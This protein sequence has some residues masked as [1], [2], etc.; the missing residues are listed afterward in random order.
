MSDTIGFFRL[1]LQ[2]EPH[3]ATL[4][5]HLAEVLLD[6]SEL[7]AAIRAASEAV[8]LDGKLVSAWVIRATALKCQGNWLEAM[9]DYQ[10]AARLA[11]DRSSVHV[12]AA[13]CAAELD[14]L[15]E[16]ERWLRRA[17]ALDPANKEAL[18]NLGSVLVRLDRLEDARGPCLAAL[19][20]DA[21]ILSA[22]QNL[23]EIL[24]HSDPAA[25]RAHR[26]FAYR[27]K[28][29]FIEPAYQEQC[30]VLVLSA[31]DA[32]NVPIRHIM[33][34]SRFTIIRWYV[35]YATPGQADQLPSYDLV[36]NAIGDPDFVPA[37]NGETAA[38][39]SAQGDRLLNPLA[40]VATTAR[41]TLSALLAGVPNILVPRTVRFGTRGPA[42][43]EAVCDA[44]VTF[45]VLVR[46]IGSHG[47]AGVIKA[48]G[49]GDL[50]AAAGGN[51]Y[52]TEFVD[53]QS[54]DAC[55][56]KYRVIFV[57]GRAYPYHLAIGPHWL[58]HYWTSGMEQAAWKRAEEAAFL[59]DPA[60]AIGGS[61]WAAMEEIGGRLQLHYA[62][63]DFGILADG[64]VIVFEANATMLVHPET[65]PA[66][67]YRCAAV[68]HIQQ[69]FADMIDRRVAGH[70]RLYRR[71]PN[72]MADRV[73]FEPT[74]PL[75]DR[76]FSRLE[77]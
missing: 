41:D 60:A 29:L 16:A 37:F 50:S 72:P 19:A 17:V 2:Q 35:E 6:A 15:E 28:Q 40:R 56:R 24:A 11:P 13:G 4:H 63:I 39:V 8:A 31:A 67:A 48:D 58:V 5:C 45:P 74:D 12:G 61:A 75:R 54:P 42:L 25:A 69:A 55:Y 71:V 38:F 3:S 76:Q 52:V 23:S 49:V 77:P 46:P 57:D 47:G 20:L 34:R 26:E 14:R 10:T 18:A 43:P 44:A 21:T 9:A 53:F 27:Q 1:L 32:A 70:R 51:C 66:F 73:G 7:D 30:R 33:P 22:H 68:Q 36:F 59:T 64:R 62:G 65:D